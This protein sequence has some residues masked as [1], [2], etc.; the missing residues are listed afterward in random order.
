MIYILRVIQSFK[1]AFRGIFFMHRFSTNIPLYYLYTAVVILLSIYFQINYF[2]IVV[3]LVM[4]LFVICAEMINTVIEEV[5]NLIT[6]EHRT[7]A[8]VAKDVAA[9]MVL[10]ATI[11]YIIVTFFVFTPHIVEFFK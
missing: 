6:Q 9:G 11:S 3:L 4:A 2:E 5:I 1:H 7:P 8:R 10:M